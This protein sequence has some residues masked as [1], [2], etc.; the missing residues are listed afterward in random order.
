MQRIWD[1]WSQIGFLE[2]NNV[3]ALTGRLMSHCKMMISRN[4]LPRWFW[5]PTHFLL[6]CSFGNSHQDRTVQE[7]ANQ[8][9]FG[10]V[11]I[12]PRLVGLYKGWNTSILECQPGFERC[13]LSNK[14]LIPRRLILRHRRFV[15]LLEISA[16]HGWLFMETGNVLVSPSEMEG[17]LV[18]AIKGARKGCILLF[19][20]IKK[21]WLFDIIWSPIC[22]LEMRS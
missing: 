7:V 17:M 1:F 10:P 15:E 11:F 9:K 13:S 6:F 8:T 20:Q 16:W 4:G 14:N 21:L 18:K 3:W 12:S 2:P 22:S 19:L 5:W